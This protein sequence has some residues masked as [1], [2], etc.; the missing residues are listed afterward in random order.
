MQWAGA[1]P[2]LK[3]RIFHS[4][5]SSHTRPVA[6]TFSGGRPSKYKSW[7][8]E[9]LYLTYQC[10]QWSELSVRRAAETYNVPPSTLHDRLTGKVPFNKKSGP[11]KYLSESEE[12]ELENFLVECAR[13]GYARSRKEILVQA[14]LGEKGMEVV[15]TAGWW[16]SF[17]RRHPESHPPVC[18]ALCI[19][20]C[21]SQQSSYI[22]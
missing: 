19:C 6:V 14:A 10:V 17:R 11:G 5:H 22:G 3:E 15:V 2:P 8:E 7:N 12:D 18:R 13:V 1:F 21:S 9:N 20:T 4:S 16:E